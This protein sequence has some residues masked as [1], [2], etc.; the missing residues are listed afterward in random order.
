MI[1]KQ[2]GVSL[3]EMLITIVVSSI[4]FA[5]MFVSYNMISG[6]SSG[7]TARANV[8]KNSRLA[9]DMIQQDIALA[10]YTNLSRG[11]KILPTPIITI[12][13]NSDKP[14][15]ISIVRHE[16]KNSEIKTVRISYQ[17]KSVSSNFLAKQ[18]EIY[19]DTTATW[20]IDAD[21]GGYAFE[22]VVD[23]FYDLQ[24][25]M[26]DLNRNK[27]SDLDLI[28]SIDI[29]AVFISDSVTKN[30]QNFYFVNDNH[31]L[32][33]SEKVMAEKFLLTVNLQNMVLR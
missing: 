6:S 24:F 30:T 17:I 23:N 29:H 18:K 15:E 14:D 3:V 27:I 11:G 8:N 26:R 22:K 7:I 1:N 31:T 16:W 28:N 9:L 19:D 25:V 33:I 12:T 20:S 10:G 21:K 13:D 5:G 32:T 2:Q 4:I